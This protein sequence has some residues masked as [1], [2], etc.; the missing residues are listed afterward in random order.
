MV[1]CVRKLK[2]L[3]LLFT[4]GMLLM[5]G[6]NGS[7][8][9]SQ[10]PGIVHF[11]PDS[12][13]FWSNPANWTTS[14][15]PAFANVSLA[16]TNFLPCRGGPF[17]LCY[18]SGPSSGPEDLSCT[19][20]PD[21]HY[22]N[23]QCFNIPYGVYFVDINGI[24]NYPVYQDTI[25]QCG[26]DGSLCQTT[27]SAPVCQRINQGNLIP[28]TS[29]YSAFS[30]DCIPTNGLGQTNCSRAPYVGC[31]TAPCFA[32]NQPG[33]V[34]CSCPVFD[35]PYQ[36][37]QNG[38]ACTLGGD[39]VWSAAFAPPATPTATPTPSAA[40]DGAVPAAV[41]SPGAC[42]P[43][44]PGAT[45]CPLYVPGSTTLPP[46]SGVN[47]TVVCQEYNSCLQ[48]GGVQA[49]YTCDAT[50]CT[51]EC[52]DRDLLQTACSGL[53]GCDISEIV[54]AET[55]AECSCC[56]S[57]LCKCD[58]DATTNKEIAALDQQQRDRGIKPQCDIN[59][60]LCGSP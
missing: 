43:D 27:D 14:Y 21:G 4:I 9:G 23:C 40:A 17:A 57:Q 31:M 47:C 35:G 45:G 51:D 19:L 3:G 11:V 30:F 10:A 42:V 22:A 50:L 60:T 2:H 26:A 41:P 7:G 56:A 32:T 49:G 13:A 34:Q 29:L 38:Q 20:T 39:L 53:T 36:V 1:E 15:G 59:G 8:A 46:G 18:Y 55:A 12:L 44:A 25:A 24:L 54:K 5:A 37:G 33:I 48:T 58:P 16:S 28:G 52:N 6:C